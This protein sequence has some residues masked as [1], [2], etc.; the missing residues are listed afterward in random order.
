M[1]D[2]R[3]EEWT[4]KTRAEMSSLTRG[5]LGG[6]V[7]ML[8]LGALLIVAGCDDDDPTGP[9]EELTPVEELAG[10]SPGIHPVLSV[11]SAGAWSSG[12]PM[13]IRLHLKA[14]EVEGAVQSY[15]GE[16]RFDPRVVSVKGGRYPEALTGAWNETEDGVVRFAAVTTEELGERA[17]LELEVVAQRRLKASDFE[18]SLEEVVGAEPTAETPTFDDLTSRVVDGDRPILASHRIEIRP[19]T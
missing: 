5:W 2:D 17:A 15:Q 12:E 3:D 19:G 13:T 9:T 18:V 16:L 10:L 4:M 14:V 1:N 11:P 7:S 8:A 6:G